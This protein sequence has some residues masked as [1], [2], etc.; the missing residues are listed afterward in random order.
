MLRLRVRVDDELAVNNGAPERIQGVLV[1][2]EVQALELVVRVVAVD[3]R[4]SGQRDGHA[5]SRGSTR[6]VD[7][8]VLRVEVRLHEQQ[9][10]HAV[11]LLADPVAEVEE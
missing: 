1:V 7:R 8:L 3:L 11:R 2:R 6:Q 5:R 4:G 10:A 9:D